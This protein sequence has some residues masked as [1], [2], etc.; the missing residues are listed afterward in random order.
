M[1]PSYTPYLDFLKTA[2]YADPFMEDMSKMGDT[3]IRLE[4]QSSLFR[5]THNP[6]VFLLDFSQRKYLCMSPLIQ[7]VLGYSPQYVIDGGIDLILE[8]YHP[9][10]GKIYFDDIFFRN[11]EFLR[12][13]PVEMHP[14]FCFSYNYRFKNR[15]GEYRTILQR[16]T[17]LRSAPDG[18][19]LLMMASLT[20]ITHFKNNGKIIHTIERMNDQEPELLYKHTYFHHPEDQVMS[21][22]E[23]E[24]LKYITDGL[25]SKQIADKM[26]LSIYTIH[27]HRK[28]MLEKTNCK[29]TAELLYFAIERGLL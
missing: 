20:D 11:I 13:Q 18:I 5:D 3:I 17:I 23:L 6:I 7:P 25:S 2:K 24:V 28:N 29:N 26:A 27:N 22:R 4:R 10:D 12:R 21:K 19:P 16:F 8:K 1:R 15:K 14:G 9:Y